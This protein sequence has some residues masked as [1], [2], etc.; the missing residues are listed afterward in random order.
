MT[1]TIL[2]STTKR[3]NRPMIAKGIAHIQ[4]Q[5]ACVVLFA[6]GR[7]EARTGAQLAHGV[8][9]MRLIGPVSA[10]IS[11]ATGNSSIPWIRKAEG[12]NKHEVSGFNVDSTIVASLTDG[13]NG[14][15][16]FGVFGE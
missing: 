13:F 6:H 5:G 9:L 10:V 2:H 12:N 7:G 3:P 14:A 16:E 8:I 15:N 1:T 4:Y 11:G